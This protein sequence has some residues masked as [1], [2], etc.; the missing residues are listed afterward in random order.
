M[1]ESTRKRNNQLILAF[2]LTAIECNKYAIKS[3][4]ARGRTNNLSNQKKRVKIFSRE[5]RAMPFSVKILAESLQK[6]GNLFGRS[7]YK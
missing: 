6:Y 5:G 7:N 1:E 4:P 2:F 3:I